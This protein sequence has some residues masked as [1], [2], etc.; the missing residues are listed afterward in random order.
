[1][2]NLCQLCLTSPED[3]TRTAPSDLHVVTPSVPQ[4]P[5]V[6]PIPRD[7]QT[8]GDFKVLEKLG[9]GGMGAVYKAQQIS[10]GRL[11]ALKILPH[12]YEDDEDYVVR[13]QR[14]AAL[15]ASLNHA[16]LV[17]VYSSGYADG[18]HFIAMELVEGENLRQTI[19]RGGMTMSG[20]LRIVADVARGL[21]CGWD[22]AQLIHRDIKPSNIYIAHNGDVKLGDL[23]L[24]KS[25]LA[26]TT[27]LTQTGAAMGTAL[28]MS[29]EQIRG[30]KNLDFRADIYSLGCTLYELLT[31]KPPYEGTDQVTVINKHLNAPLPGILKAIPNCPMP[32]VKLLGKMLKKHRPERHSSYE[33]II[34]EIEWVKD[35]IEGAVASAALATEGNATQS[36]LRLGTR[37]SGQAH[38]GAAP[39]STPARKKSS[40]A[41]YAS[42]AALAVAAVILVV[43]TMDSGAKKNTAV[44]TATQ[45]ET[46]APDRAVSAEPVAGPVSN[47]APDEP[48]ANEPDSGTDTSELTWK[49]ALA[50]GPL[51]DAL[52]NRPKLPRGTP[53]PGGSEWRFPSDRST[54]AVAFRARAIVTSSADLPKFAMVLDDGSAYRAKFDPAARRWTLSYQ[55]ELGQP[56]VELDSKDGIATIADS[57]PHYMMWVRFAGRVVLSMDGRMIVQ[58]QDRSAVPGKIGLEC[59]ENVHVLIQR[60]EY[61]DMEGVSEVTGLRLLLPRAAKARAR[62]RAQD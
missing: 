47:D 12:Q 40:V 36:G 60:A 29:P 20:A 45:P 9:Q 55:R 39:I 21:Q 35:Q 34:A 6:I 38:A 15:A 57:V 7:V 30:E 37:A 18:C 49:D 52:V 51:R 2:E 19:K 56:P 61:A 44:L 62:A 53:L 33:D 46:A 16:N 1:M 14:E 54:R 59:P 3:A 23:G 22:K 58:A 32:L 11:V 24:A 4:L 10:L 28:Y 31:G 41:I 50:E 27:G 13:F 17:R 5:L 48:E 26:N 8:I 25:M 43:A 42:L